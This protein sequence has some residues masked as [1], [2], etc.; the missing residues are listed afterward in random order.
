[1]E[2]P[3]AAHVSMV[4]SASVRGG[5]DNV[6]SYA[7]LLGA[8]GNSMADIT[9]A[10]S[11]SNFP[12]APP[13]PA[14][15]SL[16]N[17]PGS[18]PVMTAK[19]PRGTS[20]RS[21][22]DSSNA[23]APLDLGREDLNAA[24]PAK[25]PLVESPRLIPDSAWQNRTSTS[26][27]L[28][29][30]SKADLE[31]KADLESK[32][33]MAP[34]T[35]THSSSDNT[36]TG[37]PLS[38]V[39]QRRMM[40]NQLAEKAPT[41]APVPSAANNRA[42]FPL[43]SKVKRDLSI[44]DGLVSRFDDRPEAVHRRKFAAGT[45]GPNAAS[46][47]G[48]QGETF[49]IR[50]PLGQDDH[51]KN[52]G[53]I[54]STVPMKKR[55]DAAL[56][57]YRRIFMLGNSVG[58]TTS[59]SFGS[60]SGG[61]PGGSGTDDDA[62]LN[63][64]AKF[65][66]RAKAVTGAWGVILTQEL[67]E[68][69]DSD[70]ETQVTEAELHAF[71]KLLDFWDNRRMNASI[72]GSI[73]LDDDDAVPL[74]EDDITGIQSLIQKLEP[75]PVDTVE[76]IADDDV[77]VSSD[78]LPESNSGMT[79]DGTGPDQ[80][81]LGNAQY[82][83]NSDRGRG[84]N[85][86]PDFAVYPDLEEATEDQDETDTRGLIERD[87]SDLKIGETTGECFI[88]TAVLPPPPPPP[89][90]PPSSFP[91]GMAPVSHAPAS[92]VNGPAVTTAI[93]P[94]P[95]PPASQSKAGQAAPIPV[96]LS[97][98]RMSLTDSTLRDPFRP[99]LPPHYPGAPFSPGAVTPSALS[100]GASPPLSAATRRRPTVS[101]D[102][103]DALVTAAPARPTSYEPG[104]AL[105]TSK[106]VDGELD[107]MSRRKSSSTGD[108]P[109]SLRSG[110]ADQPR[111]NSGMSGALEESGTRVLREGDLS[112]AQRGM[113]GFGVFARRPSST[114]FDSGLDPPKCI[115]EV[116][117]VLTSIGCSVMVKKGEGKI[118]CEV[119]LRKERMLVSVTCTK[120][121]GISTIA[122]KRGRRDRS[123]ANE[124]EFQEFVETVSGLF[125][126]QT[127]GSM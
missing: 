16:P 62:P 121:N 24:S 85:D 115:M 50:D 5:I 41:P 90:P 88:P 69:D 106:S 91:V 11:V 74:S 8:G 125:S 27:L 49:G 68:L 66:A 55:L 73:V 3:V 87:F 59:P 95:P 23:A 61:M 40:F 111:V 119:P 75:S 39:Q 76:E 83:H 116:A 31:A 104:S 1:M 105:S 81:Y 48:G 109:A 14:P 70:E 7:S 117:R 100:P 28:S 45:D 4:P 20:Q 122:F 96:D 102:T 108:G 98:V 6:P 124:T 112:I 2:L 54:D 12:P 58:I 103:A 80:D 71:G 84:D 79:Q 65:F 57:R 22:T 26:R 37:A 13:F 19:S 43:E 34:P 101:F 77:D 107:R 36:S 47:D 33:E 44:S 93:P 97:T 38:M 32:A 67:V 110:A 21:T 35:A 52:S 118:K 42:S 82:R 30:S 72:T 64:R 9:S 92:P 63:P 127:R 15:E 94:P 123:R 114:S 78:R 120:V 53:E 10:P 25:E 60:R 56:H 18:K 113:F 99:P 126:R 86:G 51:A 17:S 46:A 89:P 29:L